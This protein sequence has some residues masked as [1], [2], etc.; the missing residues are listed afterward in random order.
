METNLVE[1][2]SR[3][4]IIGF[5]RLQLR[6][7]QPIPHFPRDSPRG[8]H[9]R[10]LLSFSCFPGFPGFIDAFGGRI[11][12]LNASKREKSGNQ[13]DVLLQKRQNLHTARDCDVGFQLAQQQRFLLL[14][15][16]HHI[17]ENAKNNAIAAV[18]R[19]RFR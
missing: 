7:G 1:L 13:I 4:Q 6:F 2:V 8:A 10:R 16:G 5:Q 14:A 12:P 19:M 11:E 3:L 18:G 9:V 15:H 17:V